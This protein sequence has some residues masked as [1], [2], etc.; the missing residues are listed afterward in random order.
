M[1]D[2]DQIKT[3]HAKLSLGGADQATSSLEV[4]VAL[5]V[6]VVRPDPQLTHDIPL[7]IDLYRPNVNTD[8]SRRHR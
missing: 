7:P 2:M 8:E 4:V 1:E 5:M 3:T 6:D